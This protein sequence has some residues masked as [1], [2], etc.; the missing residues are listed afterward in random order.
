MQRPTM[1]Q[2]VKEL[3]EVLELQWK[4]SNLEHSKAADE[5]TSSHNLRVSN[6]F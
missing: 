2:I 1:D 6:F 3:E 4:H 5:G